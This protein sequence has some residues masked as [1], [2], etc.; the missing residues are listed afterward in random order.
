MRVL[1]EEGRSITIDLILLGIVK[2]KTRKKRKRN[3]IIPPYHHIS[4]GVN[5][6]DPIFL[7]IHDRI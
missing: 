4:T 2:K 5:P 7:I 6:G 1:S 3:G